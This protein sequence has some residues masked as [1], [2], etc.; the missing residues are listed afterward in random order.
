M[1]AWGTLAAGLAWLAVGTGE[2]RFLAGAA[3]YLGLAVAHVVT[4]DA[5]PAHLFSQRADRSGAAAVLVAAAAAG[6]LAATRRL[7][8][9]GA[10]AWWIAGVLAVYGVS[11][12]ILDVS[13]KVF[14]GE[15]EEAAFRS[16]H[17]AVSAFWGLLALGLLYAGLKRWRSLRVAGLALFG[18]SL[19]K[20]FL[21]DLGSLSSITRALSFL[22]IG[23]VL[24]VGGF[25]YQ[26]LAS[27]N[28][29]RSAH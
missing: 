11:I 28:G 25:F 3:G 5:P 6:A 22:A 10:W 8:K 23:M 16:G 1:V 19:A 24:L 17:T 21:F 13:G 12:A 14:P 18:V 20:L 26:R 29:R 15:T 7:A 9:A 2:R 27:D 4:L